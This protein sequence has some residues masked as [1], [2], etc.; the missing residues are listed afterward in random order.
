MRLARAE[1]AQLATIASVPWVATERNAARAGFQVAYT[2]VVLHRP[3][4]GLAPA[5]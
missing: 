2:K 5:P 1:G 4:A 3:G